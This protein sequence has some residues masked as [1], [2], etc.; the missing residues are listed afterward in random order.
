MLF[1]CVDARAI[2]SGDF[3]EG[4]GVIGE[5]GAEVGEVFLGPFGV[6]LVENDKGGL[7]EEGGVVLFEFVPE[8]FVIIKRVAV[9]DAGEV[10]DVDEH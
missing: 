5:G 2:E 10:D 7:F 9:V 6:E 4:G 8:C 3:N 1:Q